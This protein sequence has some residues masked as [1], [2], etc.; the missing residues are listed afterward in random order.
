MLRFFCPTSQQH[1]DSGVLIDED[2]YTRYRL[3][4][5]AVMCPHCERRH[6]YL[7]ADSELGAE[8]IAA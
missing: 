5:I 2:T 3:N 7:L 4:I 1:F 8:E 6:R